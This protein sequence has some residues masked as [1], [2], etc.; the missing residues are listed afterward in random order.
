MVFRLREILKDR[1]ITI[2]QFAVMSGI[3]QSNISN[4]LSGKVS[5]TLETLNRIAHTLD[6]DITE[7]FE[8]KEEVILIAK[9][10]DRTVEINDKE[11]IEFIKNKVSNGES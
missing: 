5:P 6:I 3:S 10:N 2:G 7:L 1:K 8:K 4:Y 11:L 9:F